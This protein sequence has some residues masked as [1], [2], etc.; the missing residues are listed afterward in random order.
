MDTSRER[1]ARVYEQLTS[2]LDEVFGQVPDAAWDLRTDCPE[3]TIK[4]ILAHLGA[5]EAIMAGV[6]THAADVDVSK[7][8]YATGFNEAIERDIEARRGTGVDDLLEEFRTATLKRA[9]ALRGMDDAAYETEEPATPF[10]PASSKQ[11]MP[12]RIIDLYFH[13]QDIR[14]AIDVPGHLDGEVAWFSFE[15]MRDNL[16]GVIGK[17]VKP[18][19]GTTVVFNLTAHAGTTFA[20]VTDAQGRVAFD[21]RIPEVPTVRILTDLE[22]FLMLTGGRKP[23]ALLIDAGSVQLDGDRELGLRILASLAVTP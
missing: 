17:R 7:Y 5:I 23:P 22:T 20:L 4:D 14:R 15:R 6:A 9:E 10:G 11:F 21:D 12:I 16:P 1:I 3:W 18:P 13:E 19:P 2:S 8:P